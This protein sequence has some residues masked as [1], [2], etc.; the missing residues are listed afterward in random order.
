MEGSEELCQAD[1]LRSRTAEHD[2]VDKRL[3]FWLWSLVY[4]PSESES[5]QT[6]VAIRLTGH[7]SSNSF[8]ELS[9]EGRLS[10]QGG[11][12]RRIVDLGYDTNIRVMQ[13]YYPGTA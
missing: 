6:I 9:T 2:W 11:Q 7:S 13:Y 10:W 8:S 5:S 12:R 1:D 3:C 4:R